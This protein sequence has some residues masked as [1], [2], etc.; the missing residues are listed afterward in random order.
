MK[1]GGA[2]SA[3]RT[4]SAF[5]AWCRA[6][7]QGLQELA[8]PL[9]C[10]AHGA[11][12]SPARELCVLWWTLATASG[13][14]F[15]TIGPLRLSWLKLTFLEKALM[16]ALRTPPQPPSP[17]SERGAATEARRVRAQARR[18]GAGTEPRRFDVSLQRVRAPP[19]PPLQSGHV[20]SIPP[21]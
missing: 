11:C 2:A 1:C 14:A 7:K 19:L 16:A 21:Y 13:Y 6:P 5:S 4:L 20:S 10:C 9:P 3:Q 15:S 17:R 8:R 18:Q 12:R